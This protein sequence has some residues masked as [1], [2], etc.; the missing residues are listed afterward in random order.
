MKESVETAKRGKGSEKWSERPL[1]IPPDGRFE[2]IAHR[3][4][5]FTRRR[6]GGPGRGRPVGPRRAARR[7]HEH[8]Q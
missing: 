1:V 8:R 2:E 7:A 3:R 6:C 4:H 5:D